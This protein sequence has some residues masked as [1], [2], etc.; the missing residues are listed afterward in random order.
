M[1]YVF[2]MEHSMI[3]PAKCQNIMRGWKVCEIGCER[4]CVR[5]HIPIIHP[6]VPFVIPFSKPVQGLQLK[7][8]SWRKLNFTW[9]SLMWIMCL[10]Y[11]CYLLWILFISTMENNEISVTSQ[12]PSYCFH[13]LFQTKLTSPMNHLKWM[14]VPNKAL[15]DLW[16]RRGTGGTH[17][18]FP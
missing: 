10:H 14:I 11:F 16:G 9:E 13:E 5:H 18:T 12:F 7:D 6:Q 2:F 8:H 15:T 1:I 4:P 3:P 17:R